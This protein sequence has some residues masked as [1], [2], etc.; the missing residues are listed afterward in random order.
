MIVY[1]I[2]S[3]FART[4]V[5]ITCRRTTLAMHG[6]Y[7]FELLPVLTEIL[8]KYCGWSKS[9]CDRA[10][11]EYRTYMENNCIPDYLL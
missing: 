11:V 10:T 8:Q 4:L 6:D 9:D 2:R 7:G 1:A 3:E 5:D